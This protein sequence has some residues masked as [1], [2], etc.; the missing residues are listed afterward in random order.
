M[1][2]NLFFVSIGLWIIVLLILGKFFI[3]GSTHHSADGRKYVELSA[4]EKN[5][6]LAEMRGLLTSFSGVLAGL[7]S[8]DKKKMIESAKSAGMSGHNNVES[9]HE[10]IMLK[11]PVDFKKMGMNLHKDFDS[12]ADSIEAG[13]SEKEVIQKLSNISVQCVQCHTGYRFS[14][15]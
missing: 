15:E 4:H 14:S 6:V 12:L 7:D 13:A 9:G 3:L 11:L 1:Y 2:K 5:F 10:S 8:G